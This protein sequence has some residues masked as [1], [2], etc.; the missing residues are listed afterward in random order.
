VVEIVSQTSENTACVHLP[1]KAKGGTNYA[2]G[3]VRSG[4]VVDSDESKYSPHSGGSDEDDDLN[5]KPSADNRA[6]KT[7]SPSRK[8]AVVDLDEE[9]VNII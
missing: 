7:K 1:R 8:E 4:D 2:E 3:K 9:E 6:A 5:R